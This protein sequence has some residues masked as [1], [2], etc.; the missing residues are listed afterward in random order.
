VRSM[1]ASDSLAL[2]HRSL[3]YTDLPIVISLI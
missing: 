3:G 1:E 2:S